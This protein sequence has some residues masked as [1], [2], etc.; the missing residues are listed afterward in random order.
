[1]PTPPSPIAFIDLKA[2]QALIRDR[3]EARFQAILDHGAYINGPEVR[4][5]E[6]A[7]CQFTGAAKALAVGN[8]T[9]A[10]IMPMLAMDLKAGDAV[11][12]PSFTYNATANAVLLA[13]ATPVFVDVRARD[14]NIDPED[15]DR[16]IEQ[17][18][19]E[20]RLTPKLIVAVDLFGIAADYEAIFAVAEK[21]GLMVMADAAQSFGARWNGRWAGNIAPVTATS[22]FPAKALGCYGDGGAIFF[23]DTALYEANEQIRWHGTDSARKESVRVGFNAR[24]DSLQCAVVIEKLKLIPRELERRR[25]VAAIYD[26]RLS[27]HVDP[28]SFGAGVE[29]GYGLYTIAIGNRD[30]VQAALKEDGVPTAIYYPQPLHQMKAF[31]AYAPEGGLPECERLSGRVLS[32]PMHPYL[33]DEQVEYVADRMIAAIGG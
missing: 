6:E 27:N 12:I 26:R 18:K 4:E 11:F 31:E 23:R 8:G 22:F 24:L 20:G 33:T 21:H 7:L 32:L 5:L 14:F 16:R 19:R 28:Q 25:A 30:A 2:Q 13:G 10:L 15:L 3:I 9:D 1:M 29:S 17:L